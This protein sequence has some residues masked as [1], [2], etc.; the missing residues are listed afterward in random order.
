[1]S[2]ATAPAPEP[3]SEPATAPA[4]APATQTAD[5]WGVDEA[6]LERDRAFEAE[7]RRAAR[8]AEE[9]E[10]LAT[11]LEVLA[12][13]RAEVAARAYRAWSAG[14]EDNILSDR[15]VEDLAQQQAEAFAVAEAAGGAA[16]RARERADARHEAAAAAAQ[17]ESAELSRARAHAVLRAA[18]AAEAAAHT[19]ERLGQAHEARSEE[20]AAAARRAEER[21]EAAERAHR[22]FLEAERTHRTLAEAQRRAETAETALLFGREQPAAEAAGGA[23]GACDLTPRPPAEGVFEEKGEAPGGSRVVGGSS[24]ARLEKVAGGTSAPPTAGAMAAA[25]ENGVVQWFRETLKLRTRQDAADL[26]RSLDA[27][28]S[29]AVSAAEFMRGLK[30]RGVR[31][32]KRRCLALFKMFDLD[33]SLAVT[34]DE[35]ERVV[36][37]RTPDL[38]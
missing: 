34:V 24:A 5:E 15:R 1:L 9:A 38:K 6:T 29:D 19:L 30:R 3:A 11:E 18:T 27:N 33:E 10:A 32:G 36:L 31:A 4:T 12:E 14:Q 37:G 13:R 8:A 23:Y 35:F 25:S 26:F 28:A 17:A 7:A 16:K 21:A 22:A 20:R 2:P